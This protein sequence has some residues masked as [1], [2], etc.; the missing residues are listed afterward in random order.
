MAI[1]TFVIFVC[2]MQLDWVDNI[3]IDTIRPNITLNG[4]NN[5]V[6][7]L[8]HSYIDVGATAYD[9]SYGSKTVQSTDTVTTNI[10]G[11][12]TLRYTAPDDYA[13]NLGLSITR[14]VIVL[15]LPSISLV[16]SFTILPAGTLVNSTTI[17]KP[18]HVA[19]FQIG[20]ATYAGISSDKGITIINITDIESPTMYLGVSTWTQTD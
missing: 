13:G 14:N 18:D 9:L 2:D 10:E 17:V 19:T 1:C 3:I 20:T 11:N 7:V 4:A 6:S 16:Q 12:N 5:T 8:D 15:D